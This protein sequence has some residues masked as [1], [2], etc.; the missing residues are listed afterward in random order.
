MRSSVHVPTTRSMMPSLFMSPAPSAYLQSPSSPAKSV[1]SPN[2]PIA[3]VAQ[4]RQLRAELRGDDE[5]EIAIAVD[6]ERDDAVRTRADIDVLH[7]GEMPV[8]AA[9][10]DA[11]RVARR[12]AG[13]DIHRA[14]I[15]EIGDDAWARLDADRRRRIE[16]RLRMTRSRRPC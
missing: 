10:R 5:V 8:A 7:G 6:I 12:I 9:E 2:T 16:H 15:V 1:R 4:Q 11:R 14:V 3:V 13:R